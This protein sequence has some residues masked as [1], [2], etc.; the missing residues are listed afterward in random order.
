NNIALANKETLVT[1]GEIVMQA[2][3]EKGVE[4][5]PVDSEH[6]AIWQCL[7]SRNDCDKI[8][9]TASGG[10]FRD[11]TPE[12]LANATAEQAL[13]HPT[14][15]MGRKVTIDCATMMNK[16]F[17]VI[18]AMHLFKKSVRDIEVL[19]HRQSIIHSMVKYSDGSII[20]QMSYPDM[21][22]PIQYALHYPVRG[23]T[24]FSPLDLCAQPLTFE[25]PDLQ[26]FP[27][28]KC[29]Y[30]CAEAGGV[31]TAALNAA[32][33]I[34]T[35]Y[36]YRGIIKYYDISYYINKSIEYIDV[37]SNGKDIDAILHSDRA[38]RE[39]LRELLYKR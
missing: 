31:Y 21:K 22:L 4:I 7:D 14:W 13:K 27:C 30:E 15:D 25:R 39:Y 33:E 19:I 2:A 26:K 38:T 36:F 1:G 23:N 5:F 35:D 28:L 9:L 29:A 24:Q 34:L 18:E 37:I 20:A 8:I 3:K 12:Q 6:S 10:A 16:G 32:D 11:F 17:E